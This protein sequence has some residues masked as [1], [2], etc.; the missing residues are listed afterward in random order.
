MSDLPSFSRQS[1][2]T[3]S[4]LVLGLEKFNGGKKKVKERALSSTQSRGF[5][6]KWWFL[7]KVQVFFYTSCTG[8]P[9]GAFNAI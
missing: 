3:G 6:T 4:V 2:D 5:Y 7:C 1:L 9:P 8:V